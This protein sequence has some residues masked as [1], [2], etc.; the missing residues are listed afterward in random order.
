MRYI[1]RHESVFSQKIIV[2]YNNVVVSLFFYIL[3]DFAW[4]E[5]SVEEC[6]H[7]CGGGFQT[8]TRTSRLEDQSHSEGEIFSVTV[9]C[10][11]Q[12]CPGIKF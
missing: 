7:S 11:V 10:N 9:N 12:E 8:K 5:W 2:R 4:T 3:V 6:S 1:I